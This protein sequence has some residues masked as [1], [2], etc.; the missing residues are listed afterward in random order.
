MRDRTGQP[1]AL[2]FSPVF[3]KALAQR[4]P[5]ELHLIIA[6]LQGLFE[7]TMS[8]DADDAAA[9][10]LQSLSVVGTS[11]IIE[12]VRARGTGEIRAMSLH[13]NR[14]ANAGAGNGPSHHEPRR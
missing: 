2:R 7:R 10:D 6:A 1:F 12:F 3:Q 14:Q 8:A 4:T 13:D 5:A 9:A 11:L